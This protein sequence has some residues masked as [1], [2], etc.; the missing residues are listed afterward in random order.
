LLAELTSKTKE[1]LK[2]I[3]DHKDLPIAIG[4]GD[5]D[6]YQRVQLLTEE[7]QVLFE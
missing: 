5:E 7:N 1:Y 2:Y 4:G 3:N 6:S